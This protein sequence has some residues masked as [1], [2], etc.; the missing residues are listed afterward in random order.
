MYEKD[1]GIEE[2]ESIGSDDER[3]GGPSGQSGKK[4]RMKMGEGGPESAHSGVG[5]GGV[6]PHGGGGVKD[7]S[8]QQL[9]TKKKLNF[10]QPDDVRYFNRTL[11]KGLLHSNLPLNLFHSNPYLQ[12]ILHLLD[13]GNNN[14]PTLPLMDSQGLLQQEFEELYLEAEN[15]KKSWID[16]H[17]FITLSMVKIKHTV[18]PNTFIYFVFANSGPDSCFLGISKF[19][20]INNTG[21]LTEWLLTDILNKYFTKGNTGNS[22]HKVLA[23]LSDSSSDFHQMIS[24][25]N[26]FY[27]NIAFVPSLMESFSLI[28]REIGQIPAIHNIIKKNLL[29][30]HTLLCSPYFNNILDEYHLP[31][32]LSYYTSFLTNPYGNI[33]CLCQAIDILRP[34]INDIFNSS[35]KMQKFQVNFTPHDRKV[36][37]QHQTYEKYFLMNSEI[38][39][40]LQPLW[41]L[42]NMMEQNSF[43]V[44]SFYNVSNVYEFFLKLNYHL[45]SIE[46]STSTNQNFELKHCFEVI[47]AILFKRML[48]YFYGHSSPVNIF[49]V[50]FYLT[51]NYKDIL[52]KV[53]NNVQLSD[54]MIELYHLWNGKGSAS[55]SEMDTGVPSSDVSMN[56]ILNYQNSSM[57]LFNFNNEEKNLN[58]FLLWNRLDYVNQPL[59]YL[60]KELFSIPINTYCNEFILHAVGINKDFFSLDKNYN[61]NW[62]N[63]NKLVT[64]KISLYPKQL[65]HH[66][67]T[68]A[69]THWNVTEQERISAVWSCQK[70]SYEEL[71][72]DLL[73]DTTSYMMMTKMNKEM[74]QISKGMNQFFNVEMF[75]AIYETDLVQVS[76]G[77][78]SSNGANNLMNNQG[79]Q[80]LLSSAAGTDTKTVSDYLFGV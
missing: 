16:Q 71:E 65:L 34:A 30:L 70:K 40:L 18:L 9:V 37:D 10:Q 33:Y 21:F 64:I 7:V 77:N 80:L 32:N 31:G 45:E 44:S 41:N 51:P 24:E 50:G 38:L 66:H 68:T 75:K 5:V 4:K 43:Y 67:Q 11:L 58:P 1:R 57:Y 23:F 36:I 6:I 46:I 26:K 27:P 69:T 48:I 73:V 3:V 14:S 39:I 63:L 62:D 20:D 42:I 55:A 53:I 79:N 8:Q 74:K 17:S 35:A 12:E 54:Q 56:D 2:L 61:H 19:I 78:T 29:I 76:Q 28:M 15:Y 59:I 60:A 49:S 52:Y 13:G 25:I 22:I 72:N 47:K